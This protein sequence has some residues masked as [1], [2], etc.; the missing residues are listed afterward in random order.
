MVHSLLLQSCFPMFP[1][2]PFASIWSSQ[3]WHYLALICPWNW[4]GVVGSCELSLSFWWPQRTQPCPCLWCLPFPLLAII[5]IVLKPLQV[6]WTDG[7]GGV[8]CVLSLSLPG[9]LF[10]DFL[11]S[12]S[13]LHMQQ[14][15]CHEPSRSLTSLQAQT[16]E[17]LWCALMFLFWLDYLSYSCC[18]F[19]MCDPFANS[20]HAL[21]V[22]RRFRAPCFT[23]IACM[24]QETCG[25][26]RVKICFTHQPLICAH[27]SWH[28]Y[29]IIDLV[30]VFEAWTFQSWL[31]LF[32][33]SYVMYY[34]E[35]WKP[36]LL[37]FFFSVMS[38]IIAR[39]ENPFSC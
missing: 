6:R 18:S 28:S 25:L 22:Y 33:Q 11:L 32:L 34:S 24:A 21:F 9:N 13:N 12:I 37:I 31:D 23:R 35:A 27:L 19:F 3:N 15:R 14:L 8:G 38:G 10:A 1:P 36:L 17:E 7:G 39:P 5:V 30:S 2:D 16:P 20:S 4:L 29:W 26:F